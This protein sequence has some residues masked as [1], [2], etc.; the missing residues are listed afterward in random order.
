MTLFFLDLKM[1][2]ALERRQ[3]LL[4]DQHEAIQ[5]YNRLHLRFAIFVILFLTTL[6]NAHDLYVVY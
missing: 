2:D 5:A 1:D 4:R 3:I 6:S